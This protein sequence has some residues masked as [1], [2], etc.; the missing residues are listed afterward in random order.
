MS[1]G[2]FVI[3]ESSAFFKVV[4]SMLFSAFGAISLS[5]SFK[6]SSSLCVCN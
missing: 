2:S 5:I 3:K 6:D 1:L 4:T